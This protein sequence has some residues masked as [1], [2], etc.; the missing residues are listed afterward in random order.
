MIIVLLNSAKGATCFKASIGFHKRGMAT[1][2]AEA[3]VHALQEWGQGSWVMH[4]DTFYLQKGHQVCDSRPAKTTTRVRKKAT[5]IRAILDD[6]TG[7]KLSAYSVEEVTPV[8]KATP[9]TCRARLTLTVPYTPSRAK[10]PL[11]LFEVHTKW[12]AP[13]LTQVLDNMYEVEGRHEAHL[14][15]PNVPALLSMYT[16]SELAN[17][18]HGKLKSLAIVQT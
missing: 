17:S 10:T 4:V 16:L 11:F 1:D 7:V 15:L 9:T 6:S 18:I 12:E 14:V 2:R 5:S 8:P 13:T 3:V